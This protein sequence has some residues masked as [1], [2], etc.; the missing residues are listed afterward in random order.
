MILKL[1]ENTKDGLFRCISCEDEFLGIFYDH[2]F[3]PVCKG[4]AVEHGLLDLQ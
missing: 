3:G 1:E 4:C 2:P